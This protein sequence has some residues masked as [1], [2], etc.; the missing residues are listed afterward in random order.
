MANPNAFV[1]P[2]AN[3]WGTIARNSV[4]GP[5]YE[6]F[7]LSVFKKHQ[8]LDPYFP[9]NTQFRAEM[10]NLFNRI[11]LA[12][13][14]CTQ[15]CNDYFGSGSGSAPADRPL[16]PATTHRAFV[17]VSR[18]A[19]S[20][21]MLL[22]NF[23]LLF[24]RKGFPRRTDIVISPWTPEFGQ[25]LIVSAAY[26][27][28]SNLFVQGDLLVANKFFTKSEIDAYGSAGV[29]ARALA[30]A[31]GPLLTVMFTHRS[32]R[33][34]YHAGDSREQLKLLG[35]YA[36]GLISGAICLYYLRGYC[37][38]LLHRNTPEAAGMISRLAVTMVFVGLLQALAIWALG[39]RWIKISLLYFGLGIGYW[40]TL[41][42]LGKSP[43]ELLRVMPVAAGIAFVIIFLVWI[44]AMRLRKPGA[45]AQS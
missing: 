9:V 1:A 26:V 32:R 30:T 22:A 42:F 24:W 25:F 6:D 35:L 41:L 20:A 19:A 7:D 36:F 39:S 14:A 23:V 45:P 40:L 28:G 2:A 5:G 21:V 29:L 37:L 43:A 18:V 3:T 44:V 13:P 11:N 16:G 10:Y 34:H 31:V 8:V 12:S 38:Q 15:L 27:I 4:Y 33:H 17:R